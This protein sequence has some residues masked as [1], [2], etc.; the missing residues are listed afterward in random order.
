MPQSHNPLLTAPLFLN[1]S[2][3]LHFFYVRNTKF[4]NL[5]CTLFRINIDGFSL[6]FPSFCLVRMRRTTLWRRSLAFPSTKTTRP[7]PCRRCQRK[8]P[9]ASCL[10]LWI[11]SWTMTW[12]T[13]SNL[14]TECRWL[15]PFAACQARREDSPLAHSGELGWG[16]FKGS[17]VT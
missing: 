12:W 13:R 2:W 11:S 8:P 16:T 4:R 7:S 6:H 1:Y 5:S 9:L 3:W 15:G 14:G 10:D 17:S